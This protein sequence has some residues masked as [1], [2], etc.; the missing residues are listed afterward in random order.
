M[1]VDWIT[2][3]VEE[4]ERRAGKRAEEK[5]SAKKKG[6]VFNTKIMVVKSPY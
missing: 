4:K 6:G 3:G 1:S 5:V 2:S